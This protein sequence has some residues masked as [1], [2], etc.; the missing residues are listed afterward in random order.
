MGKELEKEV[1][2]VEK[3]ISVSEP[4]VDIPELEEQEARKYYT[5]Y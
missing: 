2:A 5:T 4:A 3:K 1:K